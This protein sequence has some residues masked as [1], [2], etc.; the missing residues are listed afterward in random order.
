MG[1]QAIERREVL[2][3]IGLASVAGSF[4]G[5]HRWA[6]ACSHNP[7]KGLLAQAVRP[8]YEP[9]FFSPEQFRMVDHLAEMIIPANDTPGAKE[10]GVAEFIDFMVANKVRVTD[11]DGYQSL[12]KG[13]IDPRDNIRIGDE[14]QEQF[15]LGLAWLNSRSKSE[16]GHEFMD[17]SADQQKG[18]LQ[19]LAYRAKYKPGTEIG[20]ELFQL[21]RDYTVVGYYTTKIGL[22]SLGYPGLRMVWPKMPGCPHP[23]DPEHAHLQESG[24]RERAVLR[25][26]NQAT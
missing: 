26:A 15:V 6:F 17:V 14:V 22:Q 9:Q 23:D 24:A 1:G 2:R 12:G 19:E 11:R 7:S 5:F 16:C 3:F 13:R 20:R 21:M 10:A 4:P 18:L 25:I 8:P